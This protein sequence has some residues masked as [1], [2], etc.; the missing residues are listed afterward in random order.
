MHNIK[1]TKMMAE[2]DKSLS[3]P[4]DQILGSCKQQEQLQNLQYFHMLN[5]ET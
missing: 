5:G 3:S 1:D 2:K 4:A